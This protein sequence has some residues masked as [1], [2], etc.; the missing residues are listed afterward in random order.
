MIDGEWVSISAL[1]DRGLLPI[2][3][4]TP[5]ALLRTFQYPLF[6]IVDCFD[7]GDDVTVFRVEFQYPLFR[8]VD[9]F[10]GAVLAE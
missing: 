10:G 5:G 2:R 4:I 7:G 1:S 6:R 8:I 3:T 9:C